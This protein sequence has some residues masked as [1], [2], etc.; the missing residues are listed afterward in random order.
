MRV[1][2]VVLEELYCLLQCLLLY[3][4]E[5]HVYTKFHFDR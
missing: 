4:C 2:I 3:F 5:M 1:F